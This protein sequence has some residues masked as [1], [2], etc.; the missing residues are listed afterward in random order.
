M[1]LL[2]F[3]MVIVGTLVTLLENWIGSGDKTCVLELP[4]AYTDSMSFGLFVLENKGERLRNWLVCLHNKGRLLHI[5]KSLGCGN[6]GF[7]GCCC[8]NARWKNR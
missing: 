6:F 1:G 4:G 2:V 5:S 7:F 3:P 8:R